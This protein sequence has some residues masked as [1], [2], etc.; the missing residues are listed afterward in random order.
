MS[1]RGGSRVAGSDGRDYQ[2]RERVADHYVIR[3]VPVKLQS[4]ANVA[5]AGGRSARC[6]TPSVTNFL[7]FWLI[8]YVLLL[9]YIQLWPFQKRLQ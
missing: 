9:L 2:H 4:V 1:S 6:P 5:A 3:L 8:T 7:F